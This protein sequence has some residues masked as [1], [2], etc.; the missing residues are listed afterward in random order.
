MLDRFRSRRKAKKQLLDHGL[1]P[2]EDAD[3]ESIKN[4]LNDLLNYSDNYFTSLGISICSH[5]QTLD[6][7]TTEQLLDD[8]LYFIPKMND[9]TKKAG[10][11][12]FN[13]SF[14]YALLYLTYC[15]NNALCTDETWND[16]F[17]SIKTSMDLLTNDKKKTNSMS[18]YA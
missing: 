7:E 9:I 12:H 5:Y 10:S 17:T 2:L 8:A 15:S 18:G 16:Y 13:F 14:L 4:E 6:D 11:D 1:T 3:S